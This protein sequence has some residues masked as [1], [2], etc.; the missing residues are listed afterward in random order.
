MLYDTSMSQD[1]LETRQKM[2]LYAYFGAIIAHEVAESKMSI[3]YRNPHE[4][5]V[6]S[7]LMLIK[8]RA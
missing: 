2:K 3:K 4:R 1:D 6:K 7:E 8:V 5:H